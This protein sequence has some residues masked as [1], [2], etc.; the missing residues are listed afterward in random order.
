MPEAWKGLKAK[1][2][3]NNGEKYTQHRGIDHCFQSVE[4]F[5]FH[6]RYKCTENF[7]MEI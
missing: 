6:C 7:F 4:I 5:D 3:R 1:T 2:V